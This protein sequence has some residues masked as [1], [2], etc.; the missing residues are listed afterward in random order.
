MSLGVAVPCS[1][2]TWPW[3]LAAGSGLAAYGWGRMVGLVWGFSLPEGPLSCVLSK[4]SACRRQHAE[5]IF[6]EFGSQ[7]IHLR[8]GSRISVGPGGS[9]SLSFG[10]SERSPHCGR[11]GQPGRT[12]LVNTEPR[13]STELPCSGLGNYTLAS[14]STP[15]PVPFL[16]NHLLCAQHRSAFPRHLI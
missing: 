9:E 7:A 5:P 14:T 4:R 2:T 3:N 11:Q 16:M 1:P 10:K 13:A 15:P 6:G 12:G 8:A